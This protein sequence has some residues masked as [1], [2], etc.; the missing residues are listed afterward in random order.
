MEGGN[1]GILYNISYVYQ[2]TN[3]L[4]QDIWHI[5]LPIDGFKKSSLLIK[6]GFVMKLTNIYFNFIYCFARSN[7]LYIIPRNQREC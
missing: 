4:N 5:T 3:I 1:Q 6:L 2:R 7:L